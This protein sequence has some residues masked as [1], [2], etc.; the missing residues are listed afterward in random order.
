MINGEPAEIV[1]CLRYGDGTAAPFNLNISGSATIIMDM[2]SRMIVEAVTGLLGGYYDS[3]NN[4]LHIELAVP[5]RSS[6]ETIHCETDLTSESKA[7]KEIRENHKLSVVGWYHSHPG[8]TDNPT[9]QDVE[10]LSNYQIYYEDEKTNKKPFVGVIVS[11][12]SPLGPFGPSIFNFYHIETLSDKSEVPYYFPDCT[13]LKIAPENEFTFL[14]SVQSLLDDFASHPERIN[15]TAGVKSES[16]L[17]LLLK[18]ITHHEASARLQA[19]ISALVS[20]T[21]DYLNK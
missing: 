15:L 18:S 11:P 9:I 1:E 3:E 19:L 16:G 10:K 21:F 7:E 5:C 12:F 20:H 17:A 2:H 8:I 13:T 6:A 14:Y 4:C